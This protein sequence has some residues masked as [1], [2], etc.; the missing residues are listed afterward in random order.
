MDA[1]GVFG[2]LHGT[3]DDETASDMLRGI[4]AKRLQALKTLRRMRRK[5]LLRITGDTAEVFAS[6]LM[7]RQSPVTQ[8]VI[9][10]TVQVSRATFLMKSVTKNV[11][12]VT[13]CMTALI[14]MMNSLTPGLGAVR[15]RVS[16][17]SSA[18]SGVGCYE[19]PPA[20]F[21]AALGFTP[22]LAK[23]WLILP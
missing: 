15:A 11:S 6:K 18:V 12:A 9:P 10:V 19:P 20:A 8:R 4:E 16:S 21:L 3:L 23:S 17:V 1:L 7:P 5:P 14:R 2:D 22:C 13:K